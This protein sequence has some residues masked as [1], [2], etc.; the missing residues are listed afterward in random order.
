MAQ[1]Q[2]RPKKTI[3]SKFIPKMKNF[4]TS[5]QYEGLFVKNENKNKSVAEL[6]QKYAR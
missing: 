2:I 1:V 6:R 5:L 3:S 4:E